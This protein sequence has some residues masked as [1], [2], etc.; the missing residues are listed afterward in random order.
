MNG[1]TTTIYRKSSELPQLE[2]SNF[3]H[4][5]RLMEI[6]E[7]TPR[8]RPYMV[9]VTDKGNRILSQLLAILHIR[10]T[11]LPPF[12]LVHCRVVGEG[13]YTQSDY[14]ADQLFGEMISKLNQTI[15]NI[16]LYI[17]VSN[18]SQKMFGYR[19]LRQ[20]GF[21]PVNWMSIHNS[22]HSHAPE[23]RITPKLQK[24][25][26]TAHERG[27]HT[28]AVSNDEDFSEFSKLLRR[29]NILK[30]RRYIPDDIFFKCGR[31][32]AF[33]NEVS[34]SCHRLLCLRL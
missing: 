6:S 28:I 32:T 21:F 10:P 5:R 23:E 25:I 9:V 8:Q 2:D 11:W 26:D 22:L 27:V 34:Q 3:F 14:P 13:V 19:Q 31:R 7:Q 24:R 12:I 33:H 1:L 17:E 15:N 4:S 29:H 16:A 30:P 18:L 20:Q